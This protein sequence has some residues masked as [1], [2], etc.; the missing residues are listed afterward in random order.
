MYKNQTHFLLLI[1]RREK[2]VAAAVT[3]GDNADAYLAQVSGKVKGVTKIK[4][5]Q[6]EM[7]MKRGSDGRK[8]L[9]YLD[10]AVIFND[11]DET[12]LVARSRLEEI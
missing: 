5:A 10:K 12:A 4:V 11:Y 1:N 2:C 9:Y 3:D 7:E 6:G 8:S